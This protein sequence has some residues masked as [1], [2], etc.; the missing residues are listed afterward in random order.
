MHSIQS[1]ITILT[2]AAIFVSILVATL[3]G[4][5]SVSNIGTHN[6]EQM[7]RLLCEAGQKSLDYYFESIEDSVDMVSSYISSDLS[8]TSLDNFD[9]HMERAR[10]FFNRTVSKTNGVLTYYYR[11][12]PDISDTEPGFWYVDL[13]GEGFKEHEVT[14]ISDYDLTNNEELVWFTNP[15]NTGKPLWL[16]PYVTDNL[17]VYVLSYNVPVYKD[18]TFIGVVGIELDY[19]TM[20]HQ[21]DIITL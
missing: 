11:I 13:D 6:S 16:P 8:V 7:L 2:T 3:I 17:D 20:K 15:M 21:V 4:A 1:K 5:I 9:E 12:H 19:T 18:K 14:N 10:S